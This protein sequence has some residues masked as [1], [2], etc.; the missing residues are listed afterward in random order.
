MVTPT[1]KSGGADGYFTKVD[2]GT[3]L[4]GG[5]VIATSPAGDP[6]L[7]LRLLAEAPMSQGAVTLGAP[8]LKRAVVPASRMGRPR[9]AVVQPHRLVHQQQLQQQQ[10]Q[11]H[12]Q[13]GMLGMVANAPAAAKR[14]AAGGA[15][16][17]GKQARVAKPPPPAEVREET[18]D[19]KRQQFLDRNKVAASKCRAK[20][21]KWMME[22]EHRAKELAGA[23]AELSAQLTRLKNESDI[24]REILLAHRDCSCV[25]IQQ[26]LQVD[27][28]SKLQMLA[29]HLPMA[30]HGHRMHVAAMHADA[31][32]NALGHT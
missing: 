28:N 2:F 16:P 29:G 8:P 19:D 6:H 12:K 13:K 22:M 11:Q 14:K 1:G 25:K 21:K 24:L 9:N 10:Q 23:N 32:M 26:Y 20:K 30:F 31:S 4:D 15:M 27:G 17:A 3:P 18:P 7:G 5:S